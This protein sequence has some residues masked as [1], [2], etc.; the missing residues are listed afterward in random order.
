M[1]LPNIVMERTNQTL[2]KYQLDLDD[3]REHVERVN[4]I[5]CCLIEKVRSLPQIS[6]TDVDEIEI[7]PI[8]VVVR[9]A[10][11]EEGS[12]GMGIGMLTAQFLEIIAKHP[13]ILGDLKN[14]WDPEVGLVTKV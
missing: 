3:M 6:N 8:T 1:G 7:A 5:D 11:S 10:G 9:E 14:F 4:A 13:T 2:P 12:V